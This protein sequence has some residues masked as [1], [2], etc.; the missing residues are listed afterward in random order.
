VAGCAARLLGHPT[1]GQGPASFQDF[2][3][4]RIILY[5]KY[6]LHSGSLETFIG[7]TD[8]AEQTSDC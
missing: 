1:T 5:L 6:H 7:A 4:L 3:A 2:Y 8:A